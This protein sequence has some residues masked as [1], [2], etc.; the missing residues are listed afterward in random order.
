MPGVGLGPRQGAGLVNVFKNGGEAIDPFDSNEVCAKAIQLSLG[1]VIAFTHAHP[2]E[3]DWWSFKDAGQVGIV[4][5]GDIVV[6]WY[7]NG[8]TQP[9]TQTFPVDATFTLRVAPGDVVQITSTTTHGAS[10]SLQLGN[11]GG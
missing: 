3:S 10:Y 5:A 7:K 9:L 4:V 8:C 6:R 2:G 11:P 1:Q